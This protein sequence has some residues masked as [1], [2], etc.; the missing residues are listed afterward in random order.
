MK[1]LCSTILIAISLVV[2]VSAQTGQ[3]ISVCVGKEVTAKQSGLKVKF[4][5]VLEDS[6]CPTDANCI[7]AGNAK[8]KVEVTDKRGGKKTLELDTNAGTKRE[9]F[10]GWAIELASLTPY[11]RTNGK[12]EPAKY[13]AKVVITR[14]KE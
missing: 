13:V 11:P 2:V 14:V 4:I 9:Q 7:W 3:A 6:R 12:I 5:E 1:T 10:D 8:I